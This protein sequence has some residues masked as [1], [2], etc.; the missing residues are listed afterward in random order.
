MLQ[1]NQ[2]DIPAAAI[3]DPDSFEIVRV[4]VA[5]KGLHVSL[6]A[7]VWDD[8]AHYGIMLSDLMNHI[9]NAYHQNEGRDRNA[10]IQRINEGM[11][12]EMESPTDYP[13]GH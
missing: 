6:L 13:T 10:V 8:P 9:A 2:L 11:K 12:A 1:K 4:W 7:A 3:S 5:N